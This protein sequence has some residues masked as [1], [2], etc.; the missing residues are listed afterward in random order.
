MQTLEDVR[1]NEIWIWQLIE[2]TQLSGVVSC[3]SL[4]QT[5]KTYKICDKLVCVGCSLLE[6]GKACVPDPHSSTIQNKR[7][8]ILR[9]L[10]S[11]TDSRVR[12]IHHEDL[13]FMVIRGR[14]WIRLK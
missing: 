4:K 13:N 11:D 14:K 6:L 9:L 12:H 2:I 5:H 3:N 8:R 7:Q 1:H 10:H